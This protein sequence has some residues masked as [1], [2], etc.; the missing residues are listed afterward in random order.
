MVFHGRVVDT[1]RYLSS[2]HWLTISTLS[3]KEIVDAASLMSQFDD[4]RN[5]CS[6]RPRNV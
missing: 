6:G 3:T 1:K 2:R 5:T 4:Y